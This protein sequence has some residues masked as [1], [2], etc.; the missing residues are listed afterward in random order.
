M[1]PLSFQTARRSAEQLRKRYGRYVVGGIAL[2]LAV[3]AV[4]MIAALAV[5]GPGGVGQLLSE[6][7]GRGAHVD[8]TV[9]AETSATDPVPALGESASTQERQGAAASSRPQLVVH[10]AGQVRQPGVVLVAQG[11]R[12]I[13]AI[14]AAGGTTKSAAADAINLAA[15]VADGQQ[16]YVPSRSEVESGTAGPLGAAGAASSV[17]GGSAQQ[18]GAAAPVVNINTATAQQLESL[19]GIGPATSAK[20]IADRVSNGPYGSLQDLTRVSGIG[21][22]RVGALQGLAVAR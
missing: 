15:P 4:V 17:G 16:V 9:P 3:I 19:P 22:K 13:D 6:T 11:A 12:V 14:E 21:E 1:D 8:L 7:F 5:A 20:I 18:S 10:V 2:T